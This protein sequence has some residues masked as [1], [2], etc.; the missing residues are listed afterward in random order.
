MSAFSPVELLPNELWDEII[1]YLFTE[2]PSSKRLHH[3]P[4]LQLTE[5]PTKDLKHLA[6]CSSGFLQLVRPQLFTHV[7]LNLH[8]EPDFHSFMTKSGLARHITSIIIAVGEDSPDHRA[9]PFWWR[10]VLCYLDPAHIMVLAPPT[11]IGETI[12]SP[13]M[14]GHSWAFDIP[15]QILYME[16]E[17]R[18]DGSS[19]LPD[20]A[21]C[22]SLLR[23]RPWTSVTFNESSSLKAYN[24]YEYF[25]S[26]VPSIL[27]E[28]GMMRGEGRNMPLQRP[29][30]LPLLLHG[31][32]TF[33][34]TAVFPFY[35]HVQIVLDAVLRMGSLRRLDVQLAP[36]R[37]NH[38]TEI[39][40]RGSMDANDPW[41]ELATSYSL[42]GFTVSQMDSLKEFRSGDLHVEAVRDDLLANLNDVIGDAAWVHDGRG[43]WKRN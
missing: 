20:L 41:M 26:C 43:I 5:S 15:L 27:R 1:G 36:D 11:F 13:I 6:Q 28:W 12:G 4:S 38:V 21:S 29:R 22:T 18:F 19:K 31:L 42:I 3:A 25:L 35:N 37:N 2:P 40:Q 10:R 24:H 7:R 32:S 33:S 23:A 16:R 17:C 14:D 30:D 39:E 34:Y 8:D 9:D